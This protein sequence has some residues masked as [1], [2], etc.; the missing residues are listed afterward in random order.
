MYR[1]VTWLALREEI[2]LEDGD[3][4]GELAAEHPVELDEAGNVGIAGRT[5]HPRSAIP[6]STVQ[7]PWSRGIRK[8]AR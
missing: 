6:G 1:A 5:S 7:C 3:R 4:L 8:C 2:A